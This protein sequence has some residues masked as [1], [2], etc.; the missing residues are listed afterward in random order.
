MPPCHVPVCRFSIREQRHAI[1]KKG[2][3]RKI[4]HEF[5]HVQFH[6]YPSFLFAFHYTQHGT[7]SATTAASPS[8]Q[9]DAVPAS[10]SGE[11]EKGSGG[12]A[13]SK[14]IKSATS[15]F[16]FYQRENMGRIR[17]E[18]EAKGEPS[19]L[20]DVQKVV[21][22]EWRSLADDVRAV[23][24]NK[25]AEDRARYDAECA[26]R[27]RLLDE[28]SAR[29]RR[30]REDV[31]CESRM[32]VREEREEKVVQVRQKRELSAAEIEE[33]ETI[34]A[35]RAARQ[36]VV[37]AEHHKLA[38]ERAKQAEARLQFL[39][40][41]SD[42]FTHFGLTG[43]KTT[44]AGVKKE[45]GEGSG[46][47]AVGAKHRRAAAADE[48]E[49]MEGGPE[50]HFLLAQPPSIKHGQL[51]PYQLE[52]LNWMIRLQDNGINGILAD[53]MVRKEGVQR[54]GRPGEGRGVGDP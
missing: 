49:D 50:A 7:M 37:D 26:E 41:Q 25:A 31:I 45:Q 27:D 29:R 2:E 51:R 6:S 8:P 43:G 23:Y 39:L 40:R 32:R 18:L 15:A 4:K 42:I 38:E 47:S 44:K 13:D 54:H 10:A 52:G 22:S 1:T 12:G 48:D 17:Q 33:R 21:A 16:L 46:T 5:E 24:N 19:G 35:E 9:A 11:G 53:E 34:K 30:E 14:V 36:A 20:G 28:E 3:G